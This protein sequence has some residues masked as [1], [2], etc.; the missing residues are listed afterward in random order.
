MRQTRRGFTLI[1]LLVVIAIIAILVSLL[2]PAVQRAREAARKTECANK[3]K[4]LGLALHNYHDSHKVFPPGQVANL[5]SNDPAVGRYVNPTEPKFLIPGILPN[6]SNIATGPGYHGTSWILHILPM[7]DQGALYN[8]WNF[9]LN[10][11]TMGEVGA[12]T[13]DLAVIYPPKVNLTA[14]YCPTRRNDMFAGSRFQNTDRVDISWNSGGNDYAAVT[15]SGITFMPQ[16]RQTYWLTPAQLSTTVITATNMS[17]YSQHSSKVGMFGVNSATSMAGVSD[18]TSNVIM[19]AER[20]IFENANLAAAANNAN[21][22]LLLSSDGWCFGGPATMLSTRESPHTG[23]HYDEADS[24]HDGII[25]VCM[26]DGSVKAIGVNI[27]RRTWEN[28]GN[29]AQGSPIDIAF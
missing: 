7:I 5:F 21:L 14:L 8:F 2:L 24:L 27:D 17:P 28:L 26:G 12:T 9:N 11:R 10:V 6:Q 20:R 15:G 4:Q 25:Q 29:M 22:N 13:Q 1:E 16:Q 19:I 23:R 18:G 3:L